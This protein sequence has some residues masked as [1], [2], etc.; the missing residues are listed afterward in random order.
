[1]SFPQKMQKCPIPHKG[2]RSVK[3]QNLCGLVLADQFFDPVRA[4]GRMDQNDV[5]KRRDK[6]G[7]N[8]VRLPVP[9]HEESLLIDSS[10][11]DDRERSLPPEKDIELIL[12]VNSLP[13]IQRTVGDV[14]LP[15]HPVIR[16]LCLGN[17]YFDPFS[18]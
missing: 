10:G 16:F 5:F 15:V 9:D 2:I 1:M 11:V 17:V 12:C 14:G 4:F 8:A 18:F 6:P 13:V 3:I 7:Y